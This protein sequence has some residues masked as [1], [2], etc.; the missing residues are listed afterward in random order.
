MAVIIMIVNNMLHTPITNPLKLLHIWL[1]S[2]YVLTYNPIHNCH[3]E[4]QAE[5]YARHNA[6]MFRGTLIYCV[7]NRVRQTAITTIKARLP[8]VWEFSTLKICLALIESSIWF[9]CGPIPCILFFVPSNQ[10][11][12]K[13]FKYFAVKVVPFYSWRN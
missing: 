9:A 12:A 10:I 13:S 3:S 6:V 2:L 7:V 1:C 4:M 5:T 11:W 8:T